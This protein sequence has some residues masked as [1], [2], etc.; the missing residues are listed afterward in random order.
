MYYPEVSVRGLMIYLAAIFFFT[1][2]SLKKHTP[3]SPELAPVTQIVAASV[4]EVVWQF[5]CPWHL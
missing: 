2:D 1:Y 4:G 3:L 5:L